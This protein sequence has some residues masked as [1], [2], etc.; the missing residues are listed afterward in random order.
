METKETLKVMDQQIHLI[1]AGADLDETTFENLLAAY[2]A[3]VK[4]QNKP[5]SQEQYNEL[6]KTFE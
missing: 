2:N 6:I 4:K 3:L 5:L 1:N